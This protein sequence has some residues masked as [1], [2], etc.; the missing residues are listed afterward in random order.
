[1]QVFLGLDTSCYT[2][3]AAAVS[4]DGRVLSA[5]RLLLPV[6]MGQC[7]LRQSEAVFAH[8]QQ[9][10]RVM[11]AMMAELPVDAA[12]AG[13]AASKTP[14]DEDD[15][16]MP[17]FQAGFGLARS[18]AASLR[19]PLR[20]VSHQAGHIAAGCIGHS[21]LHAPFLA[22]HLSGG[23]TELLFC[24]ADA[25]CR[26]GG[27]LDLH[28]GQL[29]DRVGVRLGMAFPA[30]AELEK[31][32][33]TAVELPQALLPVSMEQGDLFCHL[34][35]AESALQRLLDGDKIS[36]AQAALEAFDF[37]SRTLC[38][39]LTAGQKATGARQAL[40]VGGVASS[41]LLRRLLS[42]RLRKQGSDLTVLFG[43]PQYSG[44][45]AAGVAM[46][47]REASITSRRNEH[48]RTAFGW[49]GDVSAG[50]E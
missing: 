47:A 42:A 21:P 31:L 27:S 12:I 41:G 11:E 23:T 4:E 36:P 13:I 24:G 28:A 32:A 7:G 9:L 48:G 50:G 49:Q 14:R 43:Q 38:R 8:V 19:V 35:G 6:P 25:I 10:P 45:N 34:S 29:V 20:A 26:L 15:S 39:L 22:V 30:G 40:L 37:L 17:V 33:M 18:L 46:L 1:M 16:Y 44:D 2:T 3:S 5:H